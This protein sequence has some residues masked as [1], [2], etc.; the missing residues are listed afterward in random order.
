MTDTRERRWRIPAFTWWSYAASL[1]C[2]ALGIVSL[3]V[4][5]AWFPTIIFFT[6]TPVLTA[7]GIAGVSGNFFHSHRPRNGRCSTCKYELSGLAPSPTCPE[8]GAP[9]E[10]GSHR[11]ET[12]RTKNP[13]SE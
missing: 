6:A 11:T 2:I 7:V 9:I 8:C 10:W 1:T 5:E 13:R 4:F 12:T 3:A